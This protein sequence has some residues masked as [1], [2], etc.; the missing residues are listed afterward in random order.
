[1]SLRLRRLTGATSGSLRTSALLTLYDTRRALAQGVHT[2][3]R[4]VLGPALSPYDEE[5]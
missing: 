4:T 3:S 1:M 2:A 5:C